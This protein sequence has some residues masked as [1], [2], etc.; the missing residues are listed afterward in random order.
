[1][2]QPLNTFLKQLEGNLTTNDYQSV[3]EVLSKYD[4]S[5]PGVYTFEGI[6]FNFT[7][8]GQG[9]QPY[10]RDLIMPKIK[11]IK[12]NFFSVLLD[13]FMLYPWA[14]ELDYSPAKSLFYFLNRLSS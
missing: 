14:M 5:L 4:F 10:C 3:S 13:T 6:G 2:K 1:M 11:E 12:P 7:L 8:Y 9:T